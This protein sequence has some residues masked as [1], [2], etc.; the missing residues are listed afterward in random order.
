MIKLSFDKMM[1][2]SIEALISQ[3]F[4][5]DKEML[6]KLATEHKGVVFALNDNG[7]Y[8]AAAALVFEMNDEV[9]TCALRKLY[10]TGL[11]FD[12]AARTDGCDGMMLEYTADQAS[13]MG[14]DLLT[15]RVSLADAGMLRFLSAHGFDRIVR[16]EEKDNNVVLQRDLK[17]KIS[18]CGFYA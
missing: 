3:P 10:L 5:K 1:G 13:Y 2:D 17:R 12:D 4:C 8:R 7:N 6:K 15:V 11:S 9:L 18:C 16:V 14:Y